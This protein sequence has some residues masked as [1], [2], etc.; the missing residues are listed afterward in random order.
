M[1][2]SLESKLDFRASPAV[3]TENV[4]PIENVAMNF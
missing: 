4:N 3:A 1:I 2:M